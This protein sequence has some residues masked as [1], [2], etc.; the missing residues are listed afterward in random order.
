[1]GQ[2][3][4]MKEIRE[5]IEKCA[6]CKETEKPTR[7]NKSTQKQRST[8]FNDSIAIDLTERFDR[9]SQRKMIICHIIDEFSRLSSAAYVSDKTPQMIINA[10]FTVWF[11]KLGVPKPIIND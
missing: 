6:A 5:V 7:K 2:S 3:N 1:M 4:I 11:S 10:L 8:T 9:R